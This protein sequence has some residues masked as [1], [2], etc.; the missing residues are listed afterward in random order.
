MHVGAA[1]IVAKINAFEDNL[2]LIGEYAATAASNGV[3]VLLFSE[4]VLHGATISSEAVRRALPVTAPE[5]RRVSAKARQ[6]QL[7]LLVGFLERDGGNVYNSHLIAKPNGEIKVQ[8]KYALN[9]EERANGLTAGPVER[10]TF[11]VNG[12]RCHIAICADSGAAAVQDFL[13]RD[14]CEVLFLPTAGGGSRA[15]MLARAS[16]D[17]E[18]GIAAYTERMKRVAFPFDSIG[19]CLRKHR[20][21]V[22][23]NGVGDNGFDMCQE[24]HCIIMD[25]T[26]ELAGLI[27]GAPVLEYQRSALVHAVIGN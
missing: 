10:V 17:S 6:Y 2:R 20:A 3:E 19:Y 14:K 12:L 22:T 13:D 23:C 15:N 24:G 4:A 1:Q 26:G 18:T 5:C 9:A 7:T 25:R 16:L 8:R 27:P 21:L 11:T